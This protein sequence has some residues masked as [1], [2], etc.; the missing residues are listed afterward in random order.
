[1]NIYI[2]LFR[3]LHLLG[4][5]CLLILCL[6]IIRL[7]YN[8]LLATSP[9]LLFLWICIVFICIAAILLSMLIEYTDTTSVSRA[10]IYDHTE[11]EN[12][13]NPNAT[14]Q[15][16]NTLLH[17]A[18]IANKLDTALTLIKNGANPNATNNSDEIP[19]HTAISLNKLDIALALIAKGAN[20]NATNNYANTPLHTAINLN[21]LDIALAIIHYGKVSVANLAPV[22]G[23]PTSEYIQRLYSQAN[24][25]RI[26]SYARG[27]FAGMNAS[28]R[29]T[30]RAGIKIHVMAT[31]IKDGYLT[32]MNLLRDKSP[33]GELAPSSLPHEL[34]GIILEYTGLLPSNIKLNIGK[35]DIVRRSSADL[36]GKCHPSIIYL[37]QRSRRTR[38][39]PLLYLSH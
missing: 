33:S 15:L 35:L 30:M 27:F 24:N 7:Y 39:I 4:S 38:T 34:L 14:D 18:I 9:V 19:L 1:M 25:F 8:A 12:S 11:R 31:G 17:K 5:S 37:T 32:I 10:T 3:H 13:A 26:P 23:N 36:E 6:L 20:P 28:F 2:R 29:D 21:K 16:G 22:K